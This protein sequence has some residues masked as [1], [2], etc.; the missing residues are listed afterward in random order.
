MIPRKSVTLGGQ[1]KSD[2]RARQVFGD[3]M[4]GKSS[5]VNQGDLPDRR[6][7]FRGVVLPKSR[8]GRSQSVHR[9]EEAG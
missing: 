4:R 9:S 7:V 2:G 3:G 5:H 6:T 1:R 8:V